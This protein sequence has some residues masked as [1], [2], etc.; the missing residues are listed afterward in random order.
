MEIKRISH[1]I[2][3]SEISIHCVKCRV[4]LVPDNR[5]ILTTYPP[6]KGF[7]CP[8]CGETITL[9][10]EEFPGYVFTRISEE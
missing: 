1:N 3:V 8:K 10:E 4:E 2:S 9:S 6:Q 5:C 7:H